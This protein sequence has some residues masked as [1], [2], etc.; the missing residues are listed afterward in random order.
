MIK[1]RRMRKAGHVACMG[2]GKGRNTYRILA[3]KPVGKRPLGRSRCRWVDNIEMDLRVIELGDVDW[4]DLAQDRKQWRAL[5]NTV[6]SLQA[7]YN[8]GK[9]FSICTTSSFSRMAQIHEVRLVGC[10]LLRGDKCRSHNIQVALMEK[11]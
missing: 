8:V 2:K 9:F 6:M 11:Q 4:I 3:G 7:P 5:V 10:V 1:T